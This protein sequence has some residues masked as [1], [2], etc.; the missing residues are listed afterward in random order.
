[1]SVG[2]QVTDTVSASSSG[3]ERENF[4]TTQSASSPWP[5][6]SVTKIASGEF[7]K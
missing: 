5:S 7:P 2:R 3:S 6:P 1:M 4:V